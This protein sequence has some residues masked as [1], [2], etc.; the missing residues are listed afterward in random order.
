MKKQRNFQKLWLLAAA[1]TAFMLFGC[2][3]AGNDPITRDEVIDMQRAWGDGLVA[4]STAYANG[5]NYAEIAQGVLDDLYG[6]V[7]GTVLFKPTIASEVPFRFT[8]AA[9]ASYFIG[10][11]Y[12]AEDGGFALLPWTNVRF[13]DDGE[14]ILNGATALFMGTVYLTDGDGN[15]IYVQKSLGFYRDDHGDV[16]INLHHSSVPFGQ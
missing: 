4:I 6:Y 5:E 2:D 1:M 10:G 9:A 14:I 11:G 15:E 12:I 8:E 13:G 3:R 7:D 16:R